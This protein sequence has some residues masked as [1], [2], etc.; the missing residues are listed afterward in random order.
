MAHNFILGVLEAEKKNVNT[1][2][3]YMM[4]LIQWFRITVSTM[5]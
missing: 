3:A 5:F 4:K 1:P 2:C